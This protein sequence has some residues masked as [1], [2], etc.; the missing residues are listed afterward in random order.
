MQIRTKIIEVQ[1][2]NQGMNNYIGDSSNLA[3]VNLVQLTYSSAHKI[4][5]NWW[6]LKAEPENSRDV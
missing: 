6:L 1:F 4:I 2:K 5:F 3:P